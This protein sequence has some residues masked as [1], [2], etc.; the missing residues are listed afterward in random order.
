MQIWNV[1]KLHVARTK[2]ALKLAK[3][4]K[5]AAE[6]KGSELFIMFDGEQIKPHQLEINEDTGEIS[7]RFKSSVYEIFNADSNYDAGIYDTIPVFE[8]KFRTRFQLLKS[9]TW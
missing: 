2:A 7:V 3:N 8:E 5:A 6:W 4:L 1:N 9:I